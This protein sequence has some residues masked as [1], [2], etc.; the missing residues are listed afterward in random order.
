M[1]Y[2]L[3]LDSEEEFS[4]HSIF[5]TLPSQHTVDIALPVFD[6]QLCT[7]G[8]DSCILGLVVSLPNGKNRF[9]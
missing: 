2:L 5:E 6:S 4:P 3:E 8:L 1:N 9:S 7:G